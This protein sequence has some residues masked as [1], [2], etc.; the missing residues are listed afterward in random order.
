MLVDLCPRDEILAVSQ[1]LTG[2]NDLRAA[3]A[4]GCLLEVLLPA[5]GTDG[6]A[7]VSSTERTE[8]TNSTNAPDSRQ[9]ALERI[10]EGRLVDA[11]CE[12]LHQL[13]R[14]SAHWSLREHVQRAKAGL[15]SG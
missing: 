15:A 6:P 13:C 4:V 14:E 1:R 10:A 3:V 11:A 8:S 7:G 5:S 12:L 9:L 2:R